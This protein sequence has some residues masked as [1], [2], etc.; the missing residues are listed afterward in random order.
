VIAPAPDGTEPG[1]HAAGPVRFQA[2]TV[3][4]AAGTLASSALLLASELP[5]LGPTTG[6]YVTL[7]PAITGM[8]LMPEPVRG[9]EGFPK[10]YYTDQFSDSHHYYIE[11]A[12][13]FPFV[14]AKS[15][16]GLGS[17]LK[18]F[19]RGYTHQACAIVL[20]HDEAE[21][22]NCI[23]LKNGVPVLDYRLS[24][25]SRA[26]IVHALRSVGELFFAAGA[27]EYASPVCTR[28]TV[29]SA[30]ELEHTVVEEALLTGRVLVSSAH[31]MGGCRM[32]ADPKRSVT[33]AWGRVHG[34]PDIV[35]A[36]ASL[37]PTSTKVNPY[38][39][40]MALAERNAEQI[41][42]ELS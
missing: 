7:H 1:R 31:P 36:D 6:K 4:V 13:Y 15:L 20:V 37:F 29:T 42:R 19:M 38:L 25:R 30:A 39:T 8:A 28:T 32:G 35:V 34:H 17:D 3:V 9:F 23:R 24:R 26:A 21:E 40:V 27:V 18:R 12:F 11:S 10:L 5:G 2:R 16:A 41:A 14:T 22:R 33:D